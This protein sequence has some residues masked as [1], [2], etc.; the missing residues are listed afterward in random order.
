[1]K[2]SLAALLLA[3]PMTLALSGCIVVAPGSD[4]DY[5]H[6]TA[7][8]EER[9]YQNRKK[10]ARLTVGMEY[11]AAQDYLGVPDFSEVYD[12]NGESIQVLY[13]RT[14]RVHADSQ[15]TK[16]ECTPLVFKNGKLSSWGDSAYQ[17]I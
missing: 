7:D 3:A 8:H 17:Q 9:E 2:K 14:N 1:M 10:I 12:K 11:L 13:Y 15:T 5:S 6:F 16:D 4:G